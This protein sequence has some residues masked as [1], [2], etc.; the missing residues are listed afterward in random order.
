MIELYVFVLEN[1]KERQPQLTLRKTQT[2]IV[3]KQI[4]IELGYHNH[5]YFLEFALLPNS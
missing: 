1:K 2:P 5:N 4:E 3:A